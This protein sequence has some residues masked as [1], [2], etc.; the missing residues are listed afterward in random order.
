MQDVDAPNHQDLARIEDLA[1]ALGDSWA[2]LQE[3]VR[4]R[5][6][7][8]HSPMA[9]T[10]GLDGQP[11]ARVVILRGCE[12]AERFLR[13]HTDRRSDKIA[14]LIRQPCIGLTAYDAA[15]KVQVRV[16]GQASL[17]WDDAVADQAWEGSR[18][19]S[20]ICYG[21]E[22]GPGR[23]LAGPGAFRLPADEAE[24]AAGRANFCAVRIIVER[25]EWLHL[26]HEGHRRAR[27]D[28]A[29]SANGVWL[30]P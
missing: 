19:F 29:S 13:F 15:A 3:G 21:A 26:A 22:P 6:S 28:V 18:V 25:L 9:A 5:R 16:E 11:R 12:P 8:F 27:F 7:P 2:R 14:E 24:I 17:H 30:S 4:N 1:A 23:E 20:R 10:I